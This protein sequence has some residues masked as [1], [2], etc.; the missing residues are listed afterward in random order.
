MQAIV[1]QSNLVK[2]L[3]N[4]SGGENRI[5]KGKYETDWQVWGIWF[6]WVQCITKDGIWTILG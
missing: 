4:S 6:S 3:L 1:Y 2:V 5:S